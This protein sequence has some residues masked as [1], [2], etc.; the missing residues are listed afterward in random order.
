MKATIAVLAP[1]EAE[2]IG[3][4][5]IPV[6]PVPPNAKKEPEFRYPKF[7]WKV[8]WGGIRVS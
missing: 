7:R 4:S 8:H 1:T 3:L 2:T 5:A 6:S